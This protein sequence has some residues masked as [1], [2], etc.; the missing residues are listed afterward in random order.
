MNRAKPGQINNLGTG[1]HRGNPWVY[2]TTDAPEMV[3]SE[4]YLIPLHNHLDRT[5]HLTVYCEAPD[6]SWCEREYR[7]LHSEANCVLVAPATEWT[8]YSL[9]VVG[10][11]E[12]RE[13]AQGKF[14]VIDTG[15]GRVIKHD[16]DGI[17]AQAWQ[18]K[19]AVPAAP[20][21]PAAVEDMTI[22]QLQE[23]MKAL[24]GKGFRAGTSRDD[25][26]AGLNAA[27]EA[28]EAA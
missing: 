16:A 28:K 6:G 4:G 12:L 7:V 25:M 15:T 26:I 3:D 21:K 23:R 1:S 11:V 8:L 2:W 18:A 24:T 27:L 5:D 17:T 20:D 19:H 22:P 13:K 10:P 14:D 9:N